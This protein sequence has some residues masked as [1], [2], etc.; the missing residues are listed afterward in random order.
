MFVTHG[1]SGKFGSVFTSDALSS[2]WMA[3]SLPG[4]IGIGI[5][6]CAHE[7]VTVSGK[8]VMPKRIL[9]ALAVVSWLSA[10]TAM[11]HLVVVPTLLVIEHERSSTTIMFGGTIA[12]STLV[13]PH[14]LPGTHV[15]DGMSQTVP[16]CVQS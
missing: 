11:S 15:P 13:T 14:V 8:S 6:S 3:V 5:L 16:A 10:F 1:P 7:G 2:V 9:P 12:A 4:P